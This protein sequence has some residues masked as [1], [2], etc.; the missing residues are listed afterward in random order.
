ML[1]ELSEDWLVIQIQKI[2]ILSFFLRCLLTQFLLPCRDGTFLKVTLYCLMTIHLSSSLL[3]TLTF[4]SLLDMRFKELNLVVQGRKQFTS[5]WQRQAMFTYCLVLWFKF[6][7]HPQSLCSPKRHPKGQALL[8][9]WAID[10]PFPPA[11]LFVILAQALLNSVLT[12]GHQC[13]YS[14][15]HW[16]P[17][18]PNVLQCLIRRAFHLKAG[19]QHRD[20]I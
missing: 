16:R 10:L 17:H 11:S 4:S 7:S 9:D 13:L 5:F 14:T 12:E 19:D 3:S 8:F 15:L 20:L 6:N 18:S 1:T 2:V